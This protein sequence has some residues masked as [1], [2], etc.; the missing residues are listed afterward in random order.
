MGTLAAHLTCMRKIGGGGGSFGLHTGFMLGMCACATW[1]ASTYYHYTFGR[2]Y[3]K[4]L[5]A[6]RPPAPGP[7]GPGPTGPAQ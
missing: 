6:L 3:E 2:R 4:A 7:S 5:L 1:N